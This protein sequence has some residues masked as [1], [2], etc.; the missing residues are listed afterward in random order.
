MVTKY[1][2]LAPLDPAPLQNALEI[3]PGYLIISDAPRQLP[4]KVTY[5]HI[6]E[7]PPSPPIVAPNMAHGDDNDI[8]NPQQRET[9]ERDENN[10]KQAAAS[11]M[12]ETKDND[13][14]VDI[15]MDTEQKL[16][17]T[18]NAYERNNSGLNDAQRGRMRH[19]F[20]I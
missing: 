15:S 14:R 4:L 1:S 5:D 13:E 10:S 17:D 20:N 7:Q 2:S 16:D 12:N 18:V 3:V 11:A 6:S 9:K 8:S 19:F